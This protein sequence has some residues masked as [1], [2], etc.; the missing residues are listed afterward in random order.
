MGRA[1]V[2]TVGRSGFVS[3]DLSGDSSD[4]NGR[5]SMPSVWLLQTIAGLHTEGLES[6]TVDAK[7][8]A[9]ASDDLSEAACQMVRGVA[10]SAAIEFAE[11]PTRVN[12]LIWS[13]ASGAA[14]LELARNYL[15]SSVDAGFTTG[16]TIRLDSPPIEKSN[17]QNEGAVLVTG[18]AGGLGRAAAERLIGEG[19]Q[20]II[21]DLPGDMLDQAADDLGIEGVGANLCS[22][23]DIDRLVKHPSIQGVRSLFI[24]HGI[25]AS[26]RLDENYDSH[27][28][29]L[30]VEI[31]G[32]S[33]WATYQAFKG[34]LG[35]HGSSTVVML[36][37][38]AG[39]NAEP[40]NGAYG[41]A[42]FAVVGFVRGNVERARQHGIRLHALCPGPIE[43]PLMKS[44][45]SG[46]A[47]DLG[48]SLEE[49]TNRRLGSIPLK[50][51][52]KPHDIGATASL[53][54]NLS[55][56]GVVLAPTGG[57]VLT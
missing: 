10:G 37:S 56:T 54:C 1:S 21:S 33:V 11:L 15:Q 3:L 45:F 39:L 7:V 43:T 47:R 48:I 14:D 5:I 28:G 35:R 52:G 40:G 25:G 41:A 23:G 19:K 51:A 4:W 27:S 18:G 32:T 31:N 57:E 49:F 13:G 42:K 6:I 9:V 12:S 26:S 22:P 34:L 20:V 30:S 17:N 36:S 53:F 38:V 46:F 55:A 2:S 44:I 16:A 50:K 8:S 24:H 29:K